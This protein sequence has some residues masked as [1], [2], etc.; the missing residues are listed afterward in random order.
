MATRKK[1]SKKRTTKK[2]S[3]GGKKPGLAKLATMMRGIDLCMMTTQAKD[4]T[5]HTFPMS[6]NG[7]VDFGGD[8]W[9]FTARDSRKVKELT[10]DP[11]VSLSYV[12]GT[13]R[14][15]VWIAVSGTAAIVDDAEQKSELW[16]KEL[17]RW[18]ESGPE[19][20]EVVLI[21][22]SAQRA[23]WW[24]GEEQGEVELA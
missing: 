24:S 12:G 10:K 4:R 15:P 16:Q 11:R 7:E 18:F 8:A 22:V 21:H 5:L 13:K 19:D 20:P 9:F 3:G 17:E 2:K 6:N 1:T 23:T 14:E